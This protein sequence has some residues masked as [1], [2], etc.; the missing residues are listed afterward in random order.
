MFALQARAAGGTSYADYKKNQA[1]FRGGD[2]SDRAEY[3]KDLKE[4]TERKLN[5]NIKNRWDQ[6]ALDD[7]MKNND[8]KEARYRDFSRMGTAVAAGN[9]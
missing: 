6:R 7:V 8:I 2:S 4:R 5:W 3:E 1:K 9:I